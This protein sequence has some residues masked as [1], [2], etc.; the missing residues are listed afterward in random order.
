MINKDKN[1]HIYAERERERDIKRTPGKS[2]TSRLPSTGDTSS[3][4]Y[5]VYHHAKANDL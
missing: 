4:I 2:N 5:K 1:V 3:V